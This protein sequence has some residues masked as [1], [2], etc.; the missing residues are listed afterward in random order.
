MAIHP[1]DHD[2]VLGTHG[3][4]IWIIDDITPLRGLTQEMLASA[5][6]FLPARPTVQ[7]ISAGG[8]WVNGDAAYVGPN[9]PGDAV[10]TYYQR[11]RHIFGDMKIEIVDQGGRVVGTL[12]TSKRRGLSRVTWSMRLPAPRVPPAASAAFGAAF[13]PRVLPGTYTVRMTKDTAVYTT[14][15]VVVAD[16]RVAHTAADRRA[17]FELAQKLAASLGDMSFAVDRIN[18]V[19]QALDDRAAK[20]PAND[21]LGRRLRAASTAVDGIRKKIVATK[22]GGMIT[23]EERL[24]E[25]M[26]DLYGNVVFYDGRPSQTQVERADALAR[27]LGDVVR[28]FDTWAARELGG[29]NSALVAKR[30]ERIPLITREQWEATATSAR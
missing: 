13:G 16:P 19:R 28:E 5:V 14:Q 12:P 21:A 7:K 22:E 26:T 8:G 10:I 9:P 11:R 29:L 25:N 30:L 24:R 17:G 3:R 1:R 4:G 2:L 27:E 18:S 20:L 6:S 15:L 23:G